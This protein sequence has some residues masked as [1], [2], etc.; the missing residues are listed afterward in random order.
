[1]TIESDLESP[2][3]E[4]DSKR[5]EGGLRALRE[6][7]HDAKELVRDRAEDVRD[8]SRRYADAAGRQID[9]AQ[10]RATETVREK[11]I[12]ATLAVLGAAFLVGAVFAARSPGALKKIAD[13]VRREL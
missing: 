11:P 12:T 5:P 7:A 2:N 6:A 10:R 9:V 8:Q 1:M 4:R 3:G 13:R